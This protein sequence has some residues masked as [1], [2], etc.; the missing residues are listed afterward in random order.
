MEEY[1]VGCVQGDRTLIDRLRS[2]YFRR[3][4]RGCCYLSLP[5]SFEFDVVDNKV[6]SR[7]KTRTLHEMRFE[8]SD[9]HS[10]HD[11]Q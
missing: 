11:G 7:L 6:Q 3:L 5:L 10:V 2:I 9:G 1:P 8:F 4:R